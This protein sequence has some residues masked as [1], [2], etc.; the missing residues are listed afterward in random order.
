MFFSV[1]VVHPIHDRT[2]YLT[3]DHKRRLKEEYGKIDINLKRVGVGG[4]GMWLALPKLG[5]YHLN[6]IIFANRVAI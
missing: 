2:F 6:N 3:L 5:V 1:Q 4:G